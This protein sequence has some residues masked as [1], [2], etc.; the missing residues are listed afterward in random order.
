MTGVPQLG[1]SD[2]FAIRAGV[3][4]LGL[5]EELS[6]AQRSALRQSLAE[7]GPWRKGPFRLYGEE[8]LAHWDSS[9]RWQ[10][11]L[12]APQQ[13]G[14]KQRLHG[15]EVLDLGCNNGYYLYR[16][17]GAGVSSA[18]GFDPVAAF[19]QQFRFL[20]SISPQS[21]VA[22]ERKGYQALVDYKERFDLIFCLGIL[23]H[24]TDPVSI[25]RLCRE[26]LRPGG[27]LVLETMALPEQYSG[28][29]PQCL[30]PGSRYLGSKGVWFVP[31]RA[32]LWNLLQRTGW[33]DAQISGEFAGSDDQSR[34]RF[35]DLP[36]PIEFLDPH[37]PGFTREGLPAPVRLHAWALR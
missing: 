34:T 12:E 2:H 28:E 20:E 27:C 7:L 5:P 15:A 6:D 1:P 10:R 8:V 16:M 36:A 11:A 18:I 29:Q 4:E 35:G 21:N 17:L 30:V 14:L 37:R 25:L 32:A 33:R 3:V 23:Y 22:F 9:V 24:H 31:N 26:A 19:E 13:F